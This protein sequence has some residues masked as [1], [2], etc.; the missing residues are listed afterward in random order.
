MNSCH[1]MTSM[2]GTFPDIVTS[3]NNVN[4]FIKTKNL[5]KKYTLLISVNSD[6]VIWVDFE[7]QNNNNKTKV[8]VIYFMV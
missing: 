5:A 6:Q 2:N 8:K 4:A 3:G 1:H 7:K